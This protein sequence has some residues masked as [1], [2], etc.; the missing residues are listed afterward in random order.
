VG[1]GTR[2]LD[3]CAAPGGKTAA[4]AERNPQ[5]EITAVELH[6]HRARL[7]R[8]LV[9]AANVQI[10]TAD[11]R[12]LPVSDGFDRV[13]ADVPC[14]GTGTLARNPEIKWRLTPDHLAALHNCQVEILR[15]ALEHLA[16]GGLLVYSSCSLEPEENQA[17]IEAVA[18]ASSPAGPV[19]VVDI[20]EVIETLAQQGELALPE[21]SAIT[22]G[23]FLRT[24]PGVQQCD[25]FFAAI[26]ERHA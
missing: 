21:I 17:V 11:V 25:G 14:S 3:C 23:P 24:I 2:I 1:S 12:A 20:H 6:E 10:L 7:M 8:Q 13:L 22:S 9:K 19:R 4:I 5:A 16:P 18:P 15:A 26:L